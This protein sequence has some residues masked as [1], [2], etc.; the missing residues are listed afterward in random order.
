MGVLNP[1]G[2]ALV[3]RDI[4]FLSKAG[5]LQ[6]L[7]GTVTVNDK[8]SISGLATFGGSVISSTSS[9]LYVGATQKRASWGGLFDHAIIENRVVLVNGSLPVKYDGS[10]VWNLGITAPVQSSMTA[11]GT[12]S[13][14]F[15]VADWDYRVTFV[16]G[17]GFESNADT[18][19]VVTASSQGAGK[20]HCA[21]A[22][23]PLGAANDDVVARK[24]YRTADGGSIFYYLDTIANNTAQTYNDTKTDAQLGST[25]HPTN[26]DKPPS[27]LVCI[28]ESGGRLL[29]VGSTDR[30]ILYFSLP[31]DNYEGWPSTYYYT[32][33][34]LIR[35]I[36]KVG[37]RLVV[38]T[39]SQPHAFIMPSTDVNSF[40]DIELANRIPTKSFTSL[41]RYRD[42]LLYR[43]PRGIY[44]TDGL[45]ITY[46]S[47]G[48]E[49]LFD[50][51]TTT[52]ELEASETSA[53]YISADIVFTEEAGTPVAMADAQGNTYSFSSEF[54]IVIDIQ[55]SDTYTFSA[56]T[57]VIANLASS[58]S[59]AETL[60]VDIAYE[61]THS[62]MTQAYNCFSF[63]YQNNIMY[64]GDSVGVKQMFASGRSGFTW[65]SDWSLMNHPTHYK[66]LDRAYVYA[67]G[68][69]TF[70][71]YSDY[72][73]VAVS[74]A[75]ITSTSMSWQELWVDPTIRGHVFS[76]EF[77]VSSGGAIDPPFV[78]FFVPERMDRAGT[79]M[80]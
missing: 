1:P 40:Y 62:F 36:E 11:A 4:D 8:G 57:G 16:N 2:T 12:G 80:Q 19:N 56:E 66:K 25:T 58:V 61:N 64:G 29:G 17:D 39:E 27:A 15:T 37:G 10:D 7:K 13:D 68:N 44:S 59:A 53:Y 26:H 35:G 20:T 46:M 38:I 30:T 43:G 6:G 74:T 42:Q 73:D 18:T 77:V 79:R 60:L 54:G 24:L 71:V 76:F 75:T 78:V 49:D 65:R 51:I 21:L 9:T 52:Q 72:S 14:S 48:Q 63:D 32:F 23:I 47:E 28:A 50:V 5:R 41:T 70:N 33:P 45:N 34:D 69:V 67:D 3:A 31:G 55:N 22:N